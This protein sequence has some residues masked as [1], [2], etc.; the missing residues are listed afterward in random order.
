MT[1]SYNGWTN[2]E[3]WST[4]LWLTNDEGAQAWLIDAAAGARDADPDDESDQ[5]RI[6]AEYLEQHVP[7]SGMVGDSVSWHRVD[8]REIAEAALED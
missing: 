5:V 4:N 3:T 8:W 7:D 1:D 2:W 6:L